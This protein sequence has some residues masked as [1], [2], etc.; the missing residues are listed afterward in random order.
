MKG[1]ASRTKKSTV[2]HFFPHDRK[3]IIKALGK[4]TLIE[5]LRRMLL[6]RNFESVPRLP[7]NKAR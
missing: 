1:S 5:N 2:S 6:I 4:E 7:I 3:K